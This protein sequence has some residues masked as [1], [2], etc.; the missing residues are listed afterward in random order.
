MN[1]VV[2]T[3]ILNDKAKKLSEQVD[4]MYEKI[5]N[6]QTTV[7]DI[8]L[9]AWKGSDNKAFNEKMNDYI[10]A[11][12]KMASSMQTYSDFIKEYSDKIEKED[13]KDRN[14]NIV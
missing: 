2:D 3:S 7:D 5:N 1:I 6:V 4:V 10:V 11:L 14:L 13:K 9:N 12:K 8:L